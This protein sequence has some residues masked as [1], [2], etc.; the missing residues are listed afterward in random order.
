MNHFSISFFV[1]VQTPQP[2]PIQGV[3]CQT[4]LPKTRAY[5]FVHLTLIRSSNVH[6]ARDELSNWGTDTLTQHVRTKNQDPYAWNRPTRADYPIKGLQ[7]H[8][9]KLTLIR[10]SNV[11]VARDES[12]NWGTDTLTQHVRTKNQDP[13][14]WNRPTRADYP[15]KGLQQH[16]VK[17]C[18]GFRHIQTISTIFSASHNSRIRD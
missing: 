5:T 7:R 6:V 3:R 1:L 13:Y 17:V 4:T 11:H 9:V 15:I 2:Y 14:T 18:P 8:P 10:P 16:P 12:S